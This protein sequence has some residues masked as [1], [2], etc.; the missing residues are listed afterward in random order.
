MCIY[1]EYR[2]G[3]VQA[4][5]S[6]SEVGGLNKKSTRR[7]RF[8]FD[9]P[10]VRLPPSSNGCM[11]Q[12]RAQTKRSNLLPFTN[13]NPNVIDTADTKA[14]YPYLSTKESTPSHGVAKGVRL[15]GYLH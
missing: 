13:I 2:C 10:P 6:P 4:N 12:Q 11:H 1:F 14:K 15:L 3:A 7:S 9:A 8:C 5:V